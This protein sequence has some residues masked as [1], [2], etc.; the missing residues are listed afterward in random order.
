[1]TA[2]IVDTATYLEGSIAELSLAS[3]PWQSIS[4]PSPVAIAVM[5]GQKTVRAHCLVDR[6]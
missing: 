6:P 3:G 4:T 5:V 2:A 1:M